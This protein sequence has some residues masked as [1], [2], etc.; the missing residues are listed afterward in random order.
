E[1][2][3]TGLPFADE[4]ETHVVHDV[5]ARVLRNH[6]VT[7]VRVDPDQAHH[8][9]VEPGFLPHFSERS[10][11]DRFA[12]VNGPPRHTPEA[13]IGPLLQQDLAALVEHRRT[14]PR[15]DYFW[16]S[17]ERLTGGVIEGDRGTLFRHH[18]TPVYVHR[19][20]LRST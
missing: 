18:I 16:E 2:Q 12:R 19:L 15:T 14:R 9:H 11:L 5:T 6:I 8:T 4:A 17:G 10:L 1:P 3:R 20:V 13:V 7:G